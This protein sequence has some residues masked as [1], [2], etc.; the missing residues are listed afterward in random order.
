MYISDLS[1]LV[2]FC[3]KTTMKFLTYFTES[4]SNLYEFLD[5]QAS[6]E[7]LNYITLPENT[8]HTSEGRAEKLSSIL[9]RYASLR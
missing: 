6:A 1:C 8:L 9:N 4:L 2:L 5:D 3:S 7:Y